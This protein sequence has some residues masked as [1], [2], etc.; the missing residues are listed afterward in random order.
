MN[1]QDLTPLYRNRLQEEMDRA[2]TF[3]QAS[4]AY[5]NETG[6]AMPRTD[7]GNETMKLYHKG[8]YFA[9]LFC[10]WVAFVSP[11]LLVLSLWD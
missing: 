3:V 11:I 8:G 6:G 7:P 1:A 2:R 9:M 4:T 10:I 5:A